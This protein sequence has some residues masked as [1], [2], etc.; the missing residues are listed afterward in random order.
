MATYDYK[1]QVCE[2][3]ESVKRNIM[4]SDPGYNCS[5]CGL[6]LLRLFASS[7]SVKFNGSG[8]YSTDK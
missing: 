5:E 6:K 8:F 2:I 1:C 7:F 4:E 3:V